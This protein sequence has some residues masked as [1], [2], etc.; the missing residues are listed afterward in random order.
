MLQILEC[1]PS[2]L[3]PVTP[4]TPRLCSLAP[5][6]K[7]ENK[8]SNSSDSLIAIPYF[9][10]QKRHTARTSKTRHKQPSDATAAAKWCQVLQILEC[11]PS[12][13]HPVTPSTPRLCSL[14]PPNKTCPCL[15]YQK[16]PKTIRS[17]RHK[18]PSDA[19]VA[20]KWYQVLEILECSPSPLHPVT[21]STPRLCSLAPPH[22]MQ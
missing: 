2:P 19:T 14:A 7:V 12:P 3:H 5:P 20:A 4:S 6:H 9:R 13:L 16:R 15:R 22:K 18:L 17:K 10:G 8:A 1:S 11:S 21:P